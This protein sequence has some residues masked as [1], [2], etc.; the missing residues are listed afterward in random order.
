MW[1]QS[2]MRMPTSVCHSDVYA[3]DQG[4]LAQSSATTVARQQ[5]AGGPG[6]RHEVRAERRRDLAE[7]D[8][9][10]RAR[11]VDGGGGPVDRAIGARAHRPARR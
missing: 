11:L 2:P 3:S 8:A 4:E 9:P 6:L 5:Q 1:S 10:L 7:Q